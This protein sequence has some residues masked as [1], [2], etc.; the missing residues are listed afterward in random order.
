MSISSISKHSLRKAP[1]SIAL[2]ALLFTAC[3]GGVKTID[4]TTIKG[5]NIDDL[6]I[7]DCLLPGS[8]RTLGRKLSYIA[9]RR[10]IKTSGSECG[11]RGGEYVAYDRANY[12][13]ALKIWMPIAKEGDPKAQSYVGEIYEKGLG[14]Q[15]N[16]QKAAI[17]YQ[18]AANQGYSRAKMSLG[19]LYERG[20]GVSRNNATALALYRDASGLTNQDVEF[21]TPAQRQA[22]VAQNQQL[23]QTKRDLQI[24]Q[25]RIGQLGQ[26]V[27]E[28]QAEAK[29]LAS[30]PPKVVTKTIYNT[31]TVT[32]N[33]PQ[34]EQVIQNLAREINKLKKESKQTKIKI[35]RIPQAA[36]NDNNAQTSALLAKNAQLEK[37]LAKKEA[38]IKRAEKK[39]ATLQAKTSRPV[40]TSKPVAIASPKK[41]LAKIKVKLE[42]KK[43]ELKKEEKKIARL[44]SVNKSTSNNSNL[45]GV[46]F[47]KYYA[48]V[49]GNDNYT[50]FS[51]LKTPVS[52]AKSVA[53]VLRSQYG[54]KTSILKNA[55]KR[56]MLSAFNTFVK[57]LSPKDNLLIYYAGHGQ[58]NGGGHWLPSDAKE[59]NKKSWIPNTQ[60]TNFIDAMKAKH[61]LVVA[62][63]CYSGTL[64]QSSIPRP[65]LNAKRNRAWFDAVSTTK[66]R[67]V[68]SSG[69]VKPVLDS[70]SGNH[71]V[72]ANAFLGA[73]RSGSPVMEGAGLYQALR[74]Q[75]KTASRARG[76]T[77]NPIYA[78]IKFAGH[79]AG[80]FIFLKNGRVASLDKQPQPKNDDNTT[81]HFWALREL[82]SI[83]RA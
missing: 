32:V 43:K 47:G 57:R 3:G 29:R 6:Y 4:V 40:K 62:D 27:S 16:Y 38:N 50:N 36:S 13:T 69:G 22:R 1:L 12:Q 28:L 2:G 19:S 9:P 65:L 20:L 8:V 75:V 49:I 35:V 11:I 39:M 82:L 31:R 71:S 37:E 74:Q 15:P 60:L 58:L 68:M 48:L 78:P 10:V 79:Q 44:R 54:F 64:S 52:D 21:V 55:S 30:L 76:N 72:F 41:R 46:N 66:V 70:G 33:D 73:L 51:N 67:V 56:K 61:V 5:A 24:A 23:T 81:P 77:Q 83:F 17:W 26:D 7:V 45:S 59:S 80:D 18:K 42:K 14:T 34:Q 63:S 53:S 25:G